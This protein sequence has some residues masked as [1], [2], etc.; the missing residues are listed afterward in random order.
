MTWLRA[1]RPR[2]EAA[3]MIC[4]SIGAAI[5][6]IGY[7]L[8]VG[9]QGGVIPRD[10][11]SFDLPSVPLGTVVA[12]FVWWLLGGALGALAWILIGERRLPDRPR[13][14]IQSRHRAIP[15]FIATSVCYLGLYAVRPTFLHS[16]FD[17]A[18][19]ELH[20]SVSP[21][22]IVLAMTGYSVAWMILYAAGRFMMGDDPDEGPEPSTDPDPGWDL[23]RRQATDALRP[24]RWGEP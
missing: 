21:M 11:A 14:R 12:P 2:S 19:R 24:G 9:E 3:Q 10:P 20:W 5:V 1:D 23:R 15:A 7:A 6:G 4:G 17:G 16:D 18:F 8:L 22:T 13:F